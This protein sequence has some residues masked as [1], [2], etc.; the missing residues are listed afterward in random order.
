MVDARRME[1]YCA[2]YD[3]NN[4]ELNPVSASVIDSESFKELLETKDIIF[5]G[6]GSS[7]CRKVITSKNA[8]FLD[9]IYP[10]ALGIGALASNAF[11]EG[12]FEDL[13]YFEPFYLKDF[14]SN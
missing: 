8:R 10:S 2:I 11:N 12:R 3:R 4:M 6:D 14:M 7:K 5:F 9:Q 13:A 1:V